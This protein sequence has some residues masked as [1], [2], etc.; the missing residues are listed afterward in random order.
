MRTH[1][2]ASAPD[3]RLAPPGTFAAEQYQNLRLKIERLQ[4]ARGVRVVA[5]TS[6]ATNDGK[7]LTSI[8]LAAAL[9]RGPA[10]R[11]LLIDADLRRPSVASQLGLASD[12]GPGLASAIGDGA[13]RLS[14]V[15][16]Q[17]GRSGERRVGE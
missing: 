12:E 11:V 14:D 3:A 7:T 5:V 10:S 2:V 9:T 1:T 15:V 13:T 8:N 16:R 6:P 4:K 17:A